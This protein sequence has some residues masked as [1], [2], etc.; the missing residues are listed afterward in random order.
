MQ[1][2]KEIIKRLDLL[3]SAFESGKI[4]QLHKHEVHPALDRGSRENYLYY[5]MTCSLNFQRSSPKTWQSALD[6][7]NDPETQFVFF[8]ERVVCTNIEKLKES[9]LRH[10]LALQ[11][12]KH[13]DI[14]Y[15]IS[16]TFNN[17][18]HSDPRE[19]FKAGNFDTEKVLYIVT[20][21]MKK[22]F[23]YLSGPKLSNYFIYI[24]LHYSDL[25]L[26][27]RN[28]LSIIPDTHIMQATEVLG[29][30]P[31]EQ[32][33]PLSV[34]SAWKNLLEDSEWAPVDFHAIL[35]NWSRNNFKP[36]V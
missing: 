17:E 3:K 26:K 32:I 12:N 11:P 20:T 13:V 18:F 7:W 30:L 25:K 34:E 22:S 28:S 36:E 8:P 6:T 29:I 16:K 9:L 33:N 35:W 15:K 5:T 27:N 14:W 21:E 24:L 19:L 2:Q 1:N 23:P 10:R 4:P 31:K